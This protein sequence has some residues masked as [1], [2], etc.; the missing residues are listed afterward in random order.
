MIGII[1]MKYPSISGRS[2]EKYYI[3]N[4]D[5]SWL[6]CIRRAF[7]IYYPRC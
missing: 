7:L 5:G 3:Y 4:Q 6:E 2:R 1:C